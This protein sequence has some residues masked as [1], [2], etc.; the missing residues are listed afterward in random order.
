[1]SNIPL[2]PETNSG[3]YEKGWKDGVESRGYSCK[4]GKYRNKSGFPQNQRLASRKSWMQIASPRTFRY[5]ASKFGT[6]FSGF[7]RGR[8]PYPLL[9]P[10]AAGLPAGHPGSAGTEACDADLSRR[11]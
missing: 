7:G 10:S 2:V 3:T 6:P 11:L 1:M 4:K 5:R 8:Q 9:Q